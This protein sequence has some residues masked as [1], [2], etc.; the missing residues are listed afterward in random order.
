MPTVQ[1]FNSFKEAVAEGVHDLGADSLKFM[2]TNVAPSLS[3]TVKADLT[4]I[5][6]GNG[7]TAGGIAVTVS[8]S[9]QT[10]GTYSLALD[11]AT[12]TASGGS[13]AEFRYIVLY[14]DTAGSDELIGFLDYGAGYTLTDGN[15]F[16]LTAGTFLTNA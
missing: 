6:A 13:F 9:A 12:F 4:E 14:N 15:T 3:N 1:I 5:S 8:S 10:G 2:L 11:S 16:V 7:Y